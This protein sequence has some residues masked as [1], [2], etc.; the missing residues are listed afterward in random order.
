[1]SGYSKA[2]NTIQE[3]IDNGC[4]EEAENLIRERYGRFPR[5]RSKLVDEF[6]NTLPDAF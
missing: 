5:E 6:Y 2:V 1:M 3:C 4:Y